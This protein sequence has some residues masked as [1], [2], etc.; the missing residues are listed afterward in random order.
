MKNCKQCS[1]GFEVTDTDRQFYA[2]MAVPEPT[3]CPRCRI[4][5][6]MGYRNE[7]NLYKRKCDFSGKDIVSIYPPTSPFKVYEQ[8][9]WWSDKWSPMDYGRDFDFNRSF[10]GQFRELM[11]EVP[12]INLQNS[13]NEN[14]EYGNG[15][16]NT[17]DCYLCFLSEKIDNYYY[18]N[19]SA[20]GR[21]CMDLFWCLGCELCYECIKTH[22]SYHCFWCF[23]CKSLSDCYFCEDCI[24]CKNCFGC[25][26]LRQKEY[27]IY[28]EQK[29]KEEFNVFMKNFKFTYSEVEKTKQKMMK[30]G[31]SVP[32]KSLRIHNSEN[33]I[34]DYISDSRNC[35][36]CFDVMNSENVKYAW[37]GILNN[38]YDCS[39]TGIDTNYAYDSL[40][41]FRCNNIKFCNRSENCS[42]L[43]Y[44][45]YCYG[46]DN[47]F[48]CVS[49]IKKKY[50]ILNKQYSK[51]EYEVLIPKI[52]G[53]MKFIGEYG[54]FFP[55]SISPFGYNDTLAQEYFPLA[56]EQAAKLGFPWN[57]Y[58]HP[59]I[60]GS[61]NI[62]A[63]RLPDVIGDTPDD[64]LNWA[65][66]CEKC[67][68][69][70]KLIPQ[71][72]RFYRAQNLPVPHLCHDCRHY[73]RKAKINPRVLYDRKCA[74]CSAAIQTTY[75]PD[76]P[77]KVY[78]E[79]CYLSGLY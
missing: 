32:R 47:C 8:S 50:C 1:T 7:R 12:W 69:P 29:T 25:V 13:N 60:Q 11:L 15:I 24:S 9:I 38:S 21:D 31:L 51:E 5:R 65:I 26:N 41:N 53:H 43:E 73:A 79:Q 16:A 39:N 49:L 72:L 68:K 48:G 23:N 10:F 74:K 36:E 78:C 61:R 42:D 18:C 44:C 28:N 3:W 67:A 27:C 54:E 57:D 37:D 45:D 58:V 46:C 63:S 75:S 34:G 55:P 6:R 2:K 40:S 66:E 56:K 4:Q 33:C 19:T 70:F 59:K 22:E 14:S 35:T 76:R 30:F 17:K 20:Y 77:E 64:I 62:P 52:V 71:E